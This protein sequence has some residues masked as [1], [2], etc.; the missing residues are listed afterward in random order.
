MIK[1]KIAKG[2]WPGNAPNYRKE[3]NV[4]KYGLVNTSINIFRVFVVM[5]N[6]NP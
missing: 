1:G 6:Q 4:G 2:V 5:S 3:G